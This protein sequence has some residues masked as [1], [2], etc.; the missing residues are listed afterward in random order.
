MFYS[1][2]P[3][4][5]KDKDCLNRTTFSKQIAKAIL[6]Y[7]KIDNFTI[8]L[9][10][11]WGTGKTS[12]INMVIEEIEK[13]STDMPFDEKPLIV[14]FNPWN[15][16]DCTQLISQF[17]QTL[18]AEL[19]MENGN[20]KLKAIGSALQKYSS[21]LDYT[22]YIPKIGQYLGPLKD[23]VA[24]LGN[25]FSE[26][27]T[28][29]NSLIVQKNE[30]IEA[31]EAQTQKIIVIIDDI[32]RLN[33]QQI[34]AIFQL[35]NSLAGF[36]NMI[37]LL[38]FDRDVVVRALAEEQKCDG[39]E[40]LEKIIQVPFNVPEANKNLI[41]KSFIQIYADFLFDDINPVT[42]FDRDYWEIIFPNCIS[43]YLHSMRD[44]N[45]ILNA[46]K[47]KYGLMREET[48]CVD[49]L[50]MTVLQVSAPTIYNWIYNN[51]EILTGCL[52]TAGSISSQEQKQIKKDYLDKFE[53]VYPKN[54]ALMLKVLQSLFPKFSWRTGG[55][56]FCH[57]S[58]EE[59]RYKGKIAS[60]DRIKR[61]FHLSL[62][63][64]VFTKDQI[65]QV[66]YHY[67]EE[68]LSSYFSSLMDDNILYEFLHELMAYIPDSPRN[69]HLIF[70][71]ELLY[72]QTLDKNHQRETPISPTPSSKCSL[73][74]YEI[75]NNS[76]IHANT[77]MIL[78][79]IEDAEIQTLPLV[80]EMIEKIEYAYGRRGQYYDSGAQYIPETDLEKI[81]NKVLQKLHF[82]IE[83]ETFLDY[84]GSEDVYALWNYLDKNGLDN[85][86]SFMLQEVRNLP[87]VLSFYANKWYGGKSAGW[88]FSEES[89]GKYIE[90]NLAYEKIC[91]LKNTKEFSS[92]QYRFKQIA[93]AFYLWCDPE[94]I[95][96]YRIS[97]SSVNELISK[98]EFK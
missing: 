64:I 73:C 66:V 4:M 63:D 51:D 79:L 3:I 46:F 40:Y 78:T 94:T 38:S 33:N 1:D 95:D 59:L 98:W 83:K 11:K 13:L 20:E 80:C 36:P 6:S 62:E 32:D 12:I 77:E 57:D 89:F 7:T 54:P 74:I 60:K 30:V 2:K 85:Y 96:K 81:E 44:V 23:L 90:K 14:N 87:K 67:S 88:N 50:A 49:L 24:G 42:N 43:Q 26:I 28:E 76:E 61:Y 17:F 84:R 22:A 68:Q 8:S 97:E 15:Y 37:Y 91:T 72:L 16:S 70:I 56:T 55:Y 39:D 92:L 93:I 21:I 71:K 18:Q 86:I 41:N 65:K 19:K 25:Q 45:R 48:N 69:R 82:L 53:E 35:V 5:T 58:E 9:C 34:R 47:F 27:A 52:S 10:G 75:L 31:L 29:N